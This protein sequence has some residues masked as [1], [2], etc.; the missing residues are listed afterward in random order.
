MFDQIW[1]DAVIGQGTSLLYTQMIWSVFP[2]YAIN[3]LVF[4]SNKIIGPPTSTHEYTKRIWWCMWVVVGTFFALAV[5]QDISPWI[6]QPT[7]YTEF[8][9]MRREIDVGLKSAYKSILHRYH[10]DKKKASPSKSDKEIKSEESTFLRLKRYYEILSDPTKRKAYDVFGPKILGH[11]VSQQKVLLDA[12]LWRA[13]I[14]YASIQMALYY[15][16]ILAGSFFFDTV[17]F[18]RKKSQSPGSR[19]DKIIAYCIIILT[20]LSTYF[21]VNFWAS[22]LIDVLIGR[23]LPIFQQHLLLRS[24]VFN[25]FVAKNQLNRLS[26]Y[27]NP[28]NLP[29][30]SRDDIIEICSSFISKIDACVSELEH[31]KRLDEHK[32]E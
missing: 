13:C 19:K 26:P 12:E 2:N 21:N 4:L 18:F 8:G 30:L 28:Q 15:G 24:L 6:K 29:K 14:E 10:P 31:K 5:Y 16:S 27:P 11:V 3:F 22:D 20:E 1:A 25:F 17:S 7:L 23:W 32:I 9:L